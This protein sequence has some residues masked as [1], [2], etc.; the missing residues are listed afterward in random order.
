MRPYRGGGLVEIDWTGYTALA[1]ATSVSAAGITVVLEQPIF[2]AFF[3]GLISGTAHLNGELH[4][5]C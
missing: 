2:Y 5:R 4:V 1:I 3:L